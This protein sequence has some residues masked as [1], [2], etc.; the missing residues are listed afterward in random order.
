MNKAELSMNMIV[1][2]VIALIV[3]IVVSIIFV[4]FINDKSQTYDNHSKKLTCEGNGGI[5][6]PTNQ[7]SGDTLEFFCGLDKVCC[8]I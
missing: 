5:C 6:K 8:K 7:C 1:M 2:A 3:L 4:S